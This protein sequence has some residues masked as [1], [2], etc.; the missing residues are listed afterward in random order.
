[1]KINKQTRIN[2]L[3]CVIGD[4]TI[5]KDGSTVITH[6]EAQKEYLKW[7][8]KF[9]ENQS[10]QEDHHLKTEDGQFSPLEDPQVLENDN[11]DLFWEQDESGPNQVIYDFE[12]DQVIIPIS[13]DDITP[14]I[15][16]KKVIS[17]NVSTSQRRRFR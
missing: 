11:N 7:K 16:P 12:N 8:K 14:I 1:M 3:A 9:L 4:G 17:R 2:F 15:R 10:L 13:E 5:K 6:C